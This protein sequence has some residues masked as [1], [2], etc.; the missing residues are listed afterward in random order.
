M[1]MGSSALQ[2]FTER[3]AG[4]RSSFM[5]HLSSR[6]LGVGLIVG[7][8]V[9]GALGYNLSKDSEARPPTSVERLVVEGVDMALDPAGPR[10]D[11]THSLAVQAEKLNAEQKKTALLAASAAMNRMSI[12]VDMN[13]REY[14]SGADG[15]KQRERDF[16][17]ASADYAEAMADADIGS[18][19]V[20]GDRSG[21]NTAFKTDEL[22]FSLDAIEALGGNVDTARASGGFKP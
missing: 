21:P 4:L 3:Q 9:F 10:S 12:A 8:A 1:D 20:Q 22:Q 5:D 7:G 11:A 6:S 18:P 14:S 13:S 16:V 17:Q 2:K 15:M 19:T